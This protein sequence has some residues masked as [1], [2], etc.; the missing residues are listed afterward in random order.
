MFDLFLSN[1]VLD[2]DRSFLQALESIKYDKTHHE[3][4]IHDQEKPID[5]YTQLVNRYGEA[6]WKVVDVLND[7]Y[8]HLLPKRFDLYNWL[9]H[10][11]KDE[12]AYFLN[13]VGS[14]CLNYSQYRAPSRFHIWQGKQG[15]IVGVEQKGHGFPAQKIH[16]QKIKNNEGAAFRFFQSCRSTV[17]F[18]DPEDAKMV[19]LEYKF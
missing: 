19:F 7:K 13:E 11:E 1:M 4:I 15:F 3:F 6:K 17:F 10:N 14:N 8:A 12:L 2:F 16:K 18:D 5:D 9:E